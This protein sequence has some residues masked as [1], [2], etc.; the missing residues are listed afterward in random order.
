MSSCSQLPGALWCPVTS[1]Q[2]LQ[3]ILVPPAVWPSQYLVSLGEVQIVNILPLLKAAAVNGNVALR[4]KT[5][6]EFIEENHLAKV[7]KT[8]LMV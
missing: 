8:I 1:Y 7:C 6:K 4:E 5:K 2:S 3:S